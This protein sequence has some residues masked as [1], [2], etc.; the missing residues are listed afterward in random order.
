MVAEMKE[1]FTNLKQIPVEMNL[2]LCPDVLSIKYNG[3]FPLPDTDS[4]SD[5]CPMQSESV[6]WKHVIDYTM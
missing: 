5:S 4:D 2:S 6:Q 1:T 3:S